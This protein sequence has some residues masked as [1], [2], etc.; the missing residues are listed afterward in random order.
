KSTSQVS[1]SFIEWNKT[2]GFI[3]YFRK[4]FT[5][6]S[7]PGLN[8]LMSSAIFI[9]FL[10]RVGIHSIASLNP[11][12]LLIKK[13]SSNE[14][15]LKKRRVSLLK[16]HEKFD[17][18]PSNSNI[19]QDI[20]I[21]GAS[22]QVGGAVLRRALLEK[23][24]IIAFF[25]KTIINFS[26]PNVEWSYTNLAGKEPIAM[27]DTDTPKV[28][29]HTPSLWYLPNHLE[30]FAASG[31][32]RL[33]CFSSTSIEGKANSANNYEKQLVANFQNAE[34][35]VIKRCDALGI[36]WT[37]LRPTLIY[38]IGLDRNV[39]SIVRFIKAFGFLPLAGKAKGLRQPV[40]VDDLA[41]ACI[42]IINNPN[43][44][45]KCYNL[46]G[47]EILSYHEMVGRIFDTI[48]M[49]RK[50]LQL[51]QL[52]LLI[53]MYSFVMRK[54]ETNGEIAR[55]MNADLNFD[56]ISAK[57]DFGYDPRSFLSAGSHDIFPDFT[58]EIQDYS[59]PFDSDKTQETED[60][61]PETAKQRELVNA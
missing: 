9:R 15:E 28:L 58:S 16:S 30:E 29:I 38:G 1:N 32:K 34:A 2:K 60:T 7:R 49:K 12:G 52:P 37:I 23:T 5:T 33:I 56:Y 57:N 44:Y 26:H 25:N 18:A 42:S 53:D 50:I 20:I 22:G 17:S 46:S 40:H 6:L 13:I 10:V 61:A 45:G 41:K 39:S 21:A 51:S 36:K 14:S 35:E 31:V 19:K 24:K 55:R 27:S 3:R 4:N 47:G 48:G 54:K 59:N 8:A 43:T 11:I